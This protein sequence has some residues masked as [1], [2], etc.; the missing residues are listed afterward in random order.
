M[1]KLLFPKTD[2]SPRENFRQF[3]QIIKTIV[4]FLTRKSN[5]NLRDFSLSKLFLTFFS[6]NVKISVP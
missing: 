5:N 6:N 4:L 1:T 2:N 3:K